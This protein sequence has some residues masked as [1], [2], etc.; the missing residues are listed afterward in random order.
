MD[1]IDASKRFVVWFNGKNGASSGYVTP[2]GTISPW[3]D[4]AQR[5]QTEDDARRVIGFM[6]WVDS[7]DA[8]VANSAYVCEL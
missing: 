3:A 6:G 4:R 8:S 2:V 1:K 7:T 5:H